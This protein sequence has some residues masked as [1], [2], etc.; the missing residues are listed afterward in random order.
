MIFLF[1]LSGLL[2]TNGMRT[3]FLRY[4]WLNLSFVSLLPRLIITVITVAFLMVESEAVIAFVFKQ[5]PFSYIYEQI[6]SIGFFFNMLS[7]SLLLILWIGLYFTYHFFNKSYTQELDNLRLEN[8]RNEFEM[9]NLKKQLNPHFLFNSLNSIRALV[10]EDSNLAKEAIT[11]LSSLLRTFLITNKQD[12][13][14]LSEE[15]KIVKDYLALEKIRFEDR[16]NVKVYI[17]DELYLLEVPPLILQTLVENA[18]KHGIS[19][20][21]K[22]GLIAVQVYERDN[23]YYLVVENTGRLSNEISETSVG[24]QN[25]MRRLSILYKDKA[26]FQIYEEEGKVISKITIRQEYGEKD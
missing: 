13:I 20:E 1:A 4:K 21:V 5:Q 3:V 12:T 15:I 25:I 11:K 8:S 24:H 7:A 10:T 23:A 26:S 22:G 19:K 2:L 9:I 6:F 14:P 18:I 17:E 16:L